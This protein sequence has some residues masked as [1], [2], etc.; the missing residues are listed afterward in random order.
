MPINSYEERESERVF[1]EAHVAHR[2]AM[3]IRV[4]SNSARG[5]TLP[6][7]PPSPT[8]DFRAIMG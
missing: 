1:S 2:E 5:H 7:P 3:G 8:Q 6:H 4:F